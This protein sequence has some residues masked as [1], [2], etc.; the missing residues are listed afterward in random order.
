MKILLVWSPGKN[1]PPSR[2]ACRFRC[3][4]CSEFPVVAPCSVPLHQRER[5]ELLVSFGVCGG[6]RH[7]GIN[8]WKWQDASSGTF[9]GAVTCSENWRIQEQKNL[10]KFF[11]SKT[12]Q[13]KHSEMREGE[14]SNFTKRL[15]NFKM[16]LLHF[17]Q[18]LHS[19]QFSAT[20]TGEMRLDQSDISHLSKEPQGNCKRCSLS[21]YLGRK[22]LQNCTVGAH[23]KP[24]KREKMIW[25]SS[26]VWHTLFLFQE[27]NIA[28]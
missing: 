1:I 19:L 11:T 9:L 20:V 17:Q 4:V 14:K 28:N 8:G 16:I 27:G 2:A 6:G 23:N 26:S 24:R 22:R 15:N 21:C 3:M 18:L 10:N 25:R 7:A 12:P 5:E 13:W